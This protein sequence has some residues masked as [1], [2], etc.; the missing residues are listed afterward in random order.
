MVAHD[1]QLQSYA[2]AAGC[3][4]AAGAPATGLGSGVDCSSSESMS[5]ACA[6][7]RSSKSVLSPVPCHRVRP[8]GYGSWSAR[9]RAPA[10]RPTSRR[11]GPAG[12]PARPHRR[13]AT[14]AARAPFPQYGQRRQFVEV[15]QIEMV[16]ELSGGGEHRRAP[17]HVTMTDHANPLA[18]LQRLDDLAVDRNAANVLDL[19]AGDGLA[20]GDQR[21]GFQQRPGITLRTLLPEPPDPG[22]EAL[23]HLQTITAGHLLE[24][25]GAPLAGLVQDF[26]GLFSCADEG[27]SCSSN[28]S[29]RRSR[30]AACRTRA[31]RLRAAKRDPWDRTGPRLTPANSYSVRLRTWIDAKAS[32]CTS[33]TSDSLISSSTAMKVTTTP[34]RP[35]STWNSATNGTKP[36]PSDAR[37]PRSSA[38]GSTAPRGSPGGSRTCRHGAAPRPWIPAVPPG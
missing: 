31:E 21:Q 11:R 18:L 25:E 3:S 14:G 22:R 12:R 23:A 16:E 27:R 8:A 24:F 13:R 19:A 33:S 5:A 10:D 35:S 17:R 30:R 34:R 29:P 28:S 4:E 1:M 15:L 6:S 32:F 38:R 7:S 37:A 9:A 26:E 20:V 2:P 36:P